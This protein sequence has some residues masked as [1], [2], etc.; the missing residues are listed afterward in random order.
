MNAHANATTALIDRR[1]P[2]GRALP[3]VAAAVLLLACLPAAVHAEASDLA[4]KSPE[5]LLAMAREAED[6]AARQELAAHVAERL[7]QAREQEGYDPLEVWGHLVMPLHGQ[8][9][10][11]YRQQISEDVRAQHLASPAQVAELEPAAIVEAVDVLIMCAD[12]RGAEQAYRQWV[13]GTAKLGEAT[14]HEMRKM[15][16][17]L[18][19]PR[20][21]NPVG[22]RGESERARLAAHLLDERAATAAAA[23][24]IGLEY[25]DPLSRFLHDVVDPA[26]RAQWA[27]R[28]VE[29]FAADGQQLAGLSV[30]DVGRLGRILGRLDAAAAG[31]F[32]ASWLAAADAATVQQ[33]RTGDLIT[34]AGHAV[35]RSVTGQR[36]ARIELLE[37]VD[38]VW[39]QRHQQQPLRI[40]ECESIARLWSRQVAFERARL[41]AG[42]ALERAVDPERPNYDVMG[43]MAHLMHDVGAS[44]PGV[45]HISYA[46]ALAELARRGGLWTGPDGK[47]SGRGWQRRKVAYMVNAPQSRAIVEAELLDAQGTPR[48]DTG[49]I[50][51][52][53]YRYGGE[54]GAWRQRIDAELGREGLTDDQRALWL[55]L[56]GHARSLH[57][58]PRQLTRAKSDLDEAF[59]TAQSEP[60]RFLVLR[61][62]HSY[63]TTLDQLQATAGLHQ[64][65][66]EQFSDEVLLGRID[67]AIAWTERAQQRGEHRRAHQAEQRAREAIEA[68]RTYY[69]RRL[70]AAEAVGNE[71]R[72]DRLRAAIEALDAEL[73]P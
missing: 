16:Q 31:G 52:W 47:L 9:P 57:P 44:Q 56:R 59:A 34:L 50:L 54:L 2:A 17:W 65:V 5:E 1:P 24:Q 38:A 15:A 42:R 11:A 10:A 61:Q 29:A 8:L 40:G 71:A 73:D 41:W 37:A 46:Q 26:V 60:V 14:V 22:S 23:A 21:G 72:A 62:L 19:E 30:Q 7:P 39:D 70:A 63:Y 20:M 33:M 43:R 35:D 25:W 36:A 64:S 55:V 51:G 28:L 58:V 6:A 13:S 3:L 49:R 12:P 66:R 45:E 18:N 68:R 48:V 27:G 69:Q 4:S 32:A 53:A 67:Q